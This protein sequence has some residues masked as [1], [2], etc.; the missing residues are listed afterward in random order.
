MS[1]CSDAI[2]MLVAGDIATFTAMYVD[3]ST[4]GPANPEQLAFQWGIPG[5]MVTTVIFPDATITNPTVGTFIALVDTTGLAEYK[6]T[7]VLSGQFDGDDDDTGTVKA[8]NWG[9]C[10]VTGPPFT[11]PFTEP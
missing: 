7:V 1:A 11:S 2:P 4:G 9:T 3:K 6:Q 8:A 10:Y 5:G